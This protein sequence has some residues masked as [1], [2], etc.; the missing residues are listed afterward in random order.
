MSSPE[1]SAQSPSETS[2]EVHASAAQPVISDN[3]PTDLFW[4]RIK[5]HKVLQWTVAYGA[6][7]F[8]VLN[9]VELMT[10]AFEWPHVVQSVVTLTVLLGVPVAATL[11][12]Y[13]GQ[14][15]QRRVSGQELAVLTVLLVIGGSV[16]WV[17]A[18]S[19]HEHSAN[20]GGHQGS[21]KPSEAFAPPPHSI[22]VLPFVNMSGDKEQEYFLVAAEMKRLW[23]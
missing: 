10:H 3:Q 6:A 5:R 18:R 20:A 12:W 19:S 2:A 14:R 11:A 9:A 4:A 17:Y 23:F 1:Q 7:G 15:A 8:T 22:A 16:L 21:V 13:Q